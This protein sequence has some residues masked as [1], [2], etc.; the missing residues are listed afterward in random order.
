MFVFLSV[1]FPFVKKYCQTKT[2]G[3]LASTMFREVHKKKK[4]KNE[5]KKNKTKQNDK[6]QR[7]KL[8]PTLRKVVVKYF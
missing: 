4:D 1:Y 3:G 8:Q 7:T 6:S 5:K 2:T